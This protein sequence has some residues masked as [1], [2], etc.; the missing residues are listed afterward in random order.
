MGHN[1]RWWGCRGGD[2]F[3]VGCQQPV[4]ASFSDTY[5]LAGFLKISDQVGDPTPVGLAHQFLHIRLE[6]VRVG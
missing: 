1:G 4:G 5:D 6:T 2:V 3:R